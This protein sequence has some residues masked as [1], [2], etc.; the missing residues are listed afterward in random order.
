MKPIYILTAI[1]ALTLPLS[2]KAQVESFSYTISSSTLTDS[3][4]FSLAAFNPDMG[5]LTGVTLTLN[6]DSTA[7]VEGIN[8]SGGAAS[9]TGS[10]TFG[11]TLTGPDGTTL[12]ATTV[13]G[14]LSGTAETGALSITPLSGPEVEQTVSASVPLGNLSSYVG[15]TPVNFT[16]LAP[17]G[18]GFT[19]SGSQLSGSGLFAIGGTGAVNGGSVT[20]DYTYSAPEPSTW[21]LLFG[22]LG[23][24]AFWR[25]KTRRI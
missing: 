20:V 25:S 13:S 1:A 6:L 4:S 17:S 23:L 5:T 12:T 18:A 9:F 11:T 10:V 7:T 19:S 15:T 16:L 21:A 8:V 3:D 2:L 14:V 24:L 22:G